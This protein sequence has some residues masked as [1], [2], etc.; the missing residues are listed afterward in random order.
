MYVKE[1]F[2][3]KSSQ[4]MKDGNHLFAIEQSNRKITKFARLHWI[5]S[6]PFPI[7]LTLPYDKVCEILE[8]TMFKKMKIRTIA[9]MFQMIFLF[10]RQMLVDKIEFKYDRHYLNQRVIRSS[11]HINKGFF[12]YFEFELERVIHQSPDPKFV[13]LSSQRCNEF[14]PICCCSLYG[15]WSLRQADVHIFT[16]FN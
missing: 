5:T 16:F 6:K 15:V 11:I 7:R 13:C 14:E 2:W 3:S 1:I 10:I 9:Y 12:H 4:D 8:K